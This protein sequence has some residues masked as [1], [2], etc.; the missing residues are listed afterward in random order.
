MPKSFQRKRDQTMSTFKSCPELPLQLTNYYPK[1][2]FYPTDSNTVIVSTNSCEEEA[3]YSCMYNLDTNH[4]QILHEYGG[5]FLASVVFDAP[6][7]VIV[8]FRQL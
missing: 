8:K 2:I 5:S 3:E 6:G 1:P 4:L 7:Q